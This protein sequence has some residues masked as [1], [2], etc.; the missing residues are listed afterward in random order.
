MGSVDPEA[1][2]LTASGAGPVIGLTLSTATGAPTLTGW[3]AVLLAPAV[4]GS[5]TDA[6]SALMRDGH[7]HPSPNSGRCEAAFAGALGVTLGGRNDYAG[8]VEH[9][10]LMG[11]GRPVDVEDVERAV[12]LSALVSRTAGAVAVVAMLAR[13]RRT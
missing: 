3:L 10:P 9:R 2:A 8:Q 6:R 13:S 4:G 1:S 12:R 7:R 11:G 5:R